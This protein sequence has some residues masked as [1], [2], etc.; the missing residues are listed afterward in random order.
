MCLSRQLMNPLLGQEFIRPADD[1]HGRLR[2]Y[3]CLTNCHVSTVPES[4]DNPLPLEDHG[5]PAGEG[6]S[7]PEAPRQR[8]LLAA[9]VPPL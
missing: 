1:A 7:E 9:K 6:L 3:P 5:I 4:V 2:S 8:K